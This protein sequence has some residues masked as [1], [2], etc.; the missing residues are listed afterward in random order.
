MMI[1][2]CVVCSAQLKMR[3]IN[4]KY[5]S[6][7]CKAKRNY[8]DNLQFRKKPINKCINC[9]KG[10]LAGANGMTKYCS[11]ECR[12]SVFKTPTSKKCSECNKDFSTLRP[13]KETCGPECTRIRGLRLERERRA[14]IVTKNCERCGIG[15]E[16]PRGKP[17]AG[18]LVPLCKECK[19][20][21]PMLERWKWSQGSRRQSLRMT[22]SPPSMPC[23]NCI[24]GKQSQS[25]DTG[26]ECKASALKCKP[27]IL[28]ALFV[29]QVV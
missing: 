20:S 6:K 18:D 16:A 22:F 8:L 15:F 5:C 29:R 12:T 9:G 10:F 11:K 21:I 23:E 17:K 28:D 24:H 4:Q 2:E 26:W 25:S 27:G 14:E 19:S 7:Q 13:W 1:A 3:R